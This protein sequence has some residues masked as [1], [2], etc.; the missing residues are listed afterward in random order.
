VQL[1]LVFAT[2]TK[3]TVLVDVFE[4]CSVALPVPSSVIVVVAPP[5]ILYVTTASGV[6]VN[7][8][9]T[10]VSS[11]Q[12]VVVP[13]TLAVG[14]GF[15]VTVALPLTVAVQLVVLFATLTRLTVL[16]DVFEA[17]SVAL[18]VPSK[19]IV[20]VAPPSML[21]VTTASGVPVNVKSTAASSS[22]IVVV[23]L[24]L[25]VGSGFTVTVAL[26]L[27]VAVQFV[28]VFATLTRFTV[29]VD[30]FEACNV[31]LP[32]PSNVIVVVAPPSMLYVTTASGVPV[33]VKSTAASPSQIVVVPLTLAVG[34]GLTVTVT[35]VRVLLVQFDT[36]SLASA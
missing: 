13:L 8:K 1:V 30:V 6:P 34:N 10:A 15:T 11:S 27:T 19:A 29:L 18:P 25:A 24:T 22:Q 14:S 32:V 33:K 31:A 21:Y 3:F 16:V 9:S 4:A 7:V 35:A 5:S 28:L 12:I 20:V 23:P 36:I 17:C 26:P 2:L